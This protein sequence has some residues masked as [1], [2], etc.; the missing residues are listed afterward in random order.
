MIRK[1]YRFLLTGSLIASMLFFGAV[2]IRAHH[3][4]LIDR[5]GNIRLHPMGGY[6]HGVRQGV[7]NIYLKKG[8]FI[9]APD[10]IDLD[11]V[12]NAPYQFQ[13]LTDV[14]NAVFHPDGGGGQYSIVPST[15][16]A[17]NKEGFFIFNKNFII[18]GS[19]DRWGEDQK[20]EIMAFLPGIKKELCKDIAKFTGLPKIYRL[21][22]DQSS[23]YKQNTLIEGVEAKNVMSPQ[24]LDHPKLRAHGAG[25]FQSHDKKEYVY[26]GT[27]LPQ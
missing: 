18:E 4:P 25:C 23:L 15:E 16:M 19:L 22:S 26:Y 21:R 3:W 8:I 10:S 17:D 20:P 27:I 5:G 13:Y 1:K 14:S 9:D 12:F 6:T 2:Y 11:I 7:M 24:Y